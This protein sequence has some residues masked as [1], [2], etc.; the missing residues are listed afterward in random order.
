MGCTSCGTTPGGC[1]SKGT[2]SSGGCS[3]MHVYDWLSDI[4]IAP[5]DAFN[6][7]EVSFKNGARKG[8]FINTENIDI[9]TGDRVVV[10]ASIGYDIGIVSL[11][12]ELVKIQMKKRK[13]KETD[14]YLKI[15]RIAS[16]KELD[17]IEEARSR[18]KE[19]ML[20]AR[21][22][23]RSLGL[24]M[25]LGDVEFQA[26]CKKATFYYTAN[27]RVDF[28]ELIKELAKEF[29]VKI[30]MRQIGARQEAGRVGGIGSCGRELCCS[31]WLTNFKSVNTS[32]ARY[33]NLSINQT[34]LSGQCG[35][36]KCCLNYELDTY[37]DA[38][39]DFP[40]KADFLETEA[41]NAKLIKTDVLKGLMIYVYPKSGTFY[42]IPID[43][44]KE[45]LEMNKLGKKPNDLLEVAQV[46]EKPDNI[47]YVDLVGQVS[48]KSLEKTEKRTKKKKK[49]NTPKT[50][51][52]A[53]NA[54]I[55]ENTPAR[56]P[57]PK[58]APLPR[59]TPA[60]RSNPE[61]NTEPKVTLEPKA[62]T[63][64]GAVPTP[65]KK[66]NFKKRNNKPNSPNHPNNNNK[67]P[68]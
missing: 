49:P 32:A 29:K 16:D 62:S 3:M 42:P 58:R 39:K 57:A 10:E 65:K 67:A 43:K 38:L 31:T 66:S 60:Q 64:P 68:E 50:A 48:L 30:E 11:S 41:G 33:Q 8:F 27:H 52:S 9:Y 18:E 6:I 46:Q 54:P 2:C 5:L 15:L 51:P 40:D 22:M 23:A 28:R 47:E 36:L 35:R 14:E 21:I 1:Q 55:K 7:Y 20:K 44:V 37:L 26:D 24:D 63:E 34:K 53:D 17:L 45:I 12:G 19:T 59:P 4:A 13:V 25:K 61:A 56:E